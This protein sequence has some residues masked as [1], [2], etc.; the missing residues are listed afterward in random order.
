MRVCVTSSGRAAHACIITCVAHNT[1]R[2]HA[3]TPAPCT[4]QRTTQELDFVAANVLMAI[5]ADFMLVWLP[6]PTLTYA[7]TKAAA[8]PLG[9]FSR[10]FA[11]CPDNAFQKVQPGMPAFTLMQVSG[12]L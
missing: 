12:V 4:P 7:A 9:L 10:L 8:G 5:I 2:R 6:A 11:G 3:P 1:L